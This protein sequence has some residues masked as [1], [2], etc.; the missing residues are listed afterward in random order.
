MNLKLS[1]ICSFIVCLLISVLNSNAHD[2][3][4]CGE[5]I[6]VHNDFVAQKLMNVIRYQIPNVN[7]PQ[8]RKRVQANF[9]R[10]EYYLRATG[11]PEDLKYLA[12]VESGFENVTSSVGARGFWQ[13]MPE[14][15]KE[16]GLTVS[17]SL[18]ERDNLD[19]STYAACR[20]LAYYYLEIKKKFGI[21]SWVLAVAAYN[22][23]IGNISKAIQRQGKDYF[24]M[25]L[26]QETALYVYKI[27]AVKELFEY[28]ELYMKDFGYNVFSVIQFNSDTKKYFF[29]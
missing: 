9:P 29:N 14:T 1:S 23:G 4:F 20:H 10:V 21:Y 28:P 12:I 7:L 19:K 3:I 2:I 25:H 16:L 5:R 13:L 6:P 26:N 15:A 18:D 24:T 11:L 8:L 17:S 27:I 22:F